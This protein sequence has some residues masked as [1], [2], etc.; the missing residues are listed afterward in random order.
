[1]KNSTSTVSGKARTTVKISKQ[2]VD[3]QGV[4]TIGIDVG[5]RFSH[6]CAIGVDGAIVAQGRVATTARA[7]ELLLAGVSER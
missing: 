6:Y 2:E 3:W 7:F 5:D 1:M 4:V